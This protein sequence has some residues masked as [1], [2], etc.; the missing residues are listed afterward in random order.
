MTVITF[1]KHSRPAERIEA[2][3]AALKHHVDHMTQVNRM[4]AAGNLAAIAALG[5][6]PAQIA[7]LRMPDSLGAAGFSARTIEET[8]AKIRHLERGLSVPA[9]T[10]APGF[11]GRAS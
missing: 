8:E 7:A 1:P 9:V 5:Y 4:L 3:I 2:R 6:A 11:D 10:E